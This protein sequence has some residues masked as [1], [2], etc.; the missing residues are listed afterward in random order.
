[1]FT[2]DMHWLTKILERARYS[3]TNMIKRL[4]T[5]CASPVKESWKNLLIAARILITS[6]F[7]Y[8]AEA[9]RVRSL[10]GNIIVK[11][12]QRRFTKRKTYNSTIIHL[13]SNRIA[14]MHLLK[15]ETVTL[16]SSTALL[17]V[18]ESLWTQKWQKISASTSQWIETKRKKWIFQMSLI[19]LSAVRNLRTKSAR[20]SRKWSCKIQTY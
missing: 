17:P 1:M 12:K 3:R 7:T 9:L 16:S 18:K 8:I 5:I 15:T 14:L 2:A 11:R 19:Q 4:S 13:L 10:K 6:D 20:A